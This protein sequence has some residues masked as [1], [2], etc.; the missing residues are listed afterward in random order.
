MEF[1]EYLDKLEK[2][3]QEELKPFYE[4]ERERENSS[5]NTYGIATPK[6]KSLLAEVVSIQNLKRRI[7]LSNNID[8]IVEEIK[9]ERKTG[10]SFDLDRQLELIKEYL[11][12]DKVKED[13]I[14][15]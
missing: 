2:A 9:D 11:E 7:N 5:M 14:R 1:K 10:N 15:R 8:D 6:D 3:I 13:G 12:L 4:R